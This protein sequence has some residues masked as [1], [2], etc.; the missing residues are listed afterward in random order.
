MENKLNTVEIGDSQNKSQSTINRNL[1]K[2]LEVP[3][4]EP[5]S[6]VSIECEIPTSNKQDI[7]LNEHGGNMPET[8]KMFPT[9]KKETP[10]KRMRN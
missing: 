3:M 7:L 8:K 10:Q 5:K 2:N 9:G 6:K 1:F 4:N